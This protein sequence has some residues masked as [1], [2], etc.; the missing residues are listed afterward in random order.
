MWARN[1]VQIKK[2]AITYT[3]GDFSGLMVD[4][5]LFLLQIFASKVPLN[6]FINTTIEECENLTKLMLSAEKYDY[7]W[8]LFFFFL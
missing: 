8:Y 7:R 5:D 3:Q 6:E 1:G 4:A 2:Q